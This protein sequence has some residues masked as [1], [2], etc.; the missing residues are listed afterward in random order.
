MELAYSLTMFL[1]GPTGYGNR[2]QSPKLVQEKE[3]NRK[4]RL[5]YKTRTSNGQMYNGEPGLNLPSLPHTPEDNKE[6]QLS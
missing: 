1:H 2:K 6:N 5:P 4:T 3:S